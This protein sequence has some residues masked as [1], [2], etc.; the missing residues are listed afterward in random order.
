MTTK[1]TSAKKRT[2]ASKT[3]KRVSAKPK[4]DGTPAVTS[5]TN[6]KAETHKP[7]MLHQAFELAR[8]ARDATLYMALP[9]T[10]KMVPQGDGHPVLVL[11][12]FL[13]N[14]SATGALRSWIQR[15]G[16]EAE[17]WEGPTNFG[18][19]DK[20]MDHLHKRF[21]DVWEK[22]GRK[23]VSIVGWSLG[24]VYAAE[25]ARRYPDKIRSVVTLGS[26]HSLVEEFR[27]NGN[28]ITKTGEQVPG[29]LKAVFNFLNPDGVEPEKH[30]S[31]AQDFKVPV[32]SVYTPYDGI[33]HWTSSILKENAKTENIEI[34][35]SHL[36]LGFSLQGMTVI[37]D[38]LAQ[39]KKGWKPFD[40]AKY[41]LAMIK[42]REK[43]IHRKASPTL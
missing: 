1:K 19:S 40:P 2:Q 14:D 17:A 18:P 3:K 20:V 27:A 39:P 35:T 36:G 13:T 42:K 7:S 9:M 41:P 8:A 32:T 28:D 23:P 26:P 12:G 21:E 15:I 6:Q 11:P 24:G 29:A 33:V 30:F 37:A 16:Y 22:H 25:L 38:R 4:A 5:K 34:D 10:H 31:A 43:H